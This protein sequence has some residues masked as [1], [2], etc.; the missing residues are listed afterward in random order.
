MNLSIESTWREKLE[1]EFEKEYFQD[2]T[3]FVKSEYQTETVYPEEGKIFRA[4]ETTPFDQVK[5]V[6]LG[7]DP[8]HG[9]DQA[10]GLCFSVNPEVKL[11]PSLRN[12]FKEISEDTGSEMASSG[13]LT[14]WATQGVLLINSTLTVQASKAGSHQRKGWEQFTD[15]VIE[16][17]SEERENLVFILWGAYAHKKGAKVDPKRHLILQSVH[18]SPLSAHRGFFGNNHFSKSNDYLLSNS[19]KPI[20]W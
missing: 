15:K 19:I 17:L 6:I 16:V 12:I 13:D 1:G 8:Y 11:P 3:S 9:P 18:P 4:F 10:N 2:L 20:E 5:V 14:R 7:Q